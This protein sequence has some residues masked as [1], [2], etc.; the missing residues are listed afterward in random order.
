M[1]RE[2]EK[3]GRIKP[4]DTLIEPTSGNTGIGL[5]LA[6]AVKGYK[7]IITLPEKMSKEKVD[8]LK[9]LGAE[10]VRTPTEAAWDAP[11][12]HIS[13]A[14]RM[15][16]SL[17]NAHILDQYSNTANPMAHYDGTGE[18]ILWACDDKVDMFIAGAGTGG[19]LTGTARKLKERVPGIKIVGI[20]PMGSILAYPEELNLPAPPNL[21]EGIGYDF[22]PVACDRDPNLVDKWV[23][24]EDEESFK[25][26]RRLIREEG[27]LCGGSSGSA[28]Y[29][30]IKAILEDPEVNQEGKRAVIILPDSVRNYMTKFLSDEW[31]QEQGFMDAADQKKER[32]SDWGEGTVA[33]LKPS[34]VVSIVADAPVSEAV[35]TMNSRGFDNL[36]VLDGAGKMVGLVTIG[37]LLARM[38]KTGDKAVVPSDP[39]EKAM[40]HFSKS[41]DFKIVTMGTKLGDL[42]DF[43]NEHHVAF[44]T[45]DSDA[46]KVVGVISKVDVLK[47]VMT[48]KK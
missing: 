13:V 28:V 23:K 36:P 15:Q 2:A 20:D 44:V 5:S 37:S 27:L 29:Y 21:V 22:I 40:L 31:M 11:E 32:S 47:Y 9:G 4:G 33:D 48:T 38:G 3:S 10:I 41:S 7:M 1:V 46:K 16:E 24:S 34:H 43:F 8:V 35:E 18:E 45:D 42:Q 26:S 17:E 19:T 39:V 6:A 30:G 12:S 25:M 14:K